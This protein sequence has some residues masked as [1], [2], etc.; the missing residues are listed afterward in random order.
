MHNTVEVGVM[1]DRAAIVI[2]SSQNQI[3]EGEILNKKIKNI[4]SFLYVSKVK[5][6]SICSVV[7][8]WQ[9]KCLRKLLS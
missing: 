3:K 2:P 5:N 9:K 7:T 1:D 4:V 6:S 8:L